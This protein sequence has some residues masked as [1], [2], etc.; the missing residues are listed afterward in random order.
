MKRVCRKIRS[1][2]AAGGPAALRGDDQAQDHLAECDGCF[3]FLEALVKLE[4]AFSEMP[5]LDAPDDVVNQL[6]ERP[7]LAQPVDHP[8]DK[9]AETATTRLRRFI[10]TG[11]SFLGTIRS[12]RIR[13]GL[14]AMP[15]VVLI[16]L[17]SIFILKNAVRD[18]P[19]GADLETSKSAEI[20][21]SQEFET[22]TKGSIATEDDEFRQR[23]GTLSESEESDLG[24]GR[25]NAPMKMRATEPMRRD[26]KKE[27]NEKLKIVGDLGFSSGDVPASPAPSALSEALSE[28]FAEEI[29]I[30]GSVPIV[31]VSGVGSSISMDQDNLEQRASGL[32]DRLEK[33]SPKSGE[34]ADLEAELGNDKNLPVDFKRKKNDE[35]SVGG[36]ESTGRREPSYARYTSLAASEKSSKDNRIDRVEGMM[37]FDGVDTLDATVGGFTDEM[38]IDTSAAAKFLENR[39]NINNLVFKDENGYWANTYVP[40]DRELR[41]LKARIEAQARTLDK[42]ASLG[43]LHQTSHQ[44]TQPFDSPDAS[45]LA[46]YLHADSAGVDART[47]LRIQVGIKGTNRRAGL[48]PPMNVGLVLD[49]R[50]EVSADTQATMRALVEAFAA[51]AD[52]GD[53][54]SLTIAGRH[55]GCIVPRTS[56]RHGPLSIALREAFSDVQPPIGGMSLL[57]SLNTAADTVRAEDDPSAPLGSSAVILITDQPLNADRAVFFAAHQSSVEGIPWSAIGIGSSVRLNEL[58]Q[59]VLAGQGNRR[60]LDS[61]AEANALVEREL[62][63]VSR[64]IAR[65]LRLRIDLAPGVQLVDVL[66]SESLDEAR[67]Q[68][69]RDAESAIDQRI[70][71]N[72]GIVADRGLDEPGIQIVIPSFYASDAHV[73]LLDVVVP[74]PGPIADVSARYK[75][76]VHMKN[77]VAQAHLAIGRE[78]RGPGPLE[79]NVLKND[80]AHQLGLCLRNAA[81]LAT[82]GQSSDAIRVLEDFH[83]LLVQLPGL[84][85]G[86]AN[87]GD[88]EIDQ[89]MLK[90]YINELQSGTGIELLADSMRYAGRLKTLPSSLGET[91]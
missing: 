76:L 51:A 30:T 6:L 18:M 12:A 2:L 32:N 57:Q 61:G 15:A 24:D 14:A 41:S 91:E 46:L 23:I 4:N 84:I 72:L 3:E 47:R 40:G 65:A 58:D 73:I 59:L 19:L 90:T 5:A 34:Y 9:P 13:W 78:Q 25:S 43:Q 11:T 85:D 33:E 82:A 44:A 69:V 67:A 89:L 7:E 37:M 87:D 8:I 27:A 1:T 62:R 48:R 45:A 71:R 31:D 20:Q 75:D 70:S 22:E 10:E 21:Y 80:L 60:L 28:S 79:L 56:F 74:G 35:S 83:G 64:V 86:L 49:L 42:G 54:F 52:L 53:R 38:N 36:K 63:A 68:R 16:G 29:T 55:G 88:L 39:K 66:G 17:V 81:D 50:G 26:V 77:G